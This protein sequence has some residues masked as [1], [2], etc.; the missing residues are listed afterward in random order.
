MSDTTDR[1]Y[2]MAHR[3]ANSICGV[4]FA[5]CRDEND[6]VIYMSE[7]DARNYCEWLNKGCRSS[8]V[9]YT[10]EPA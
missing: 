9:H 8:N 10:V 7:A 4:G 5:P 2:V 6:K 1:F 3:S